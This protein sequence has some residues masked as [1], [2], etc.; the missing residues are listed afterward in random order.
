MQVTSQVPWYKERW[1]W[2]LAIMP[3]TTIIV[4][5]VFLW[6][7]I[8]TND[9]L[10]SDDYYKDGLAINRI[11]KR[12]EAAHRYNLSAAAQLRGSSISLQLAGNLP[13]VPDS[14]KLTLAH[15]T[16]EGF[17]RSILLTRN[18]VGNYQ[19]KVQGLINVRYD[20]ILEPLDGAWRIAGQWHPV[21]GEML[22]MNPANLLPRSE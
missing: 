2:L 17:D 8:K 10:V 21:E 14:L 7:A 20:I 5:S 1:P 13:A 4:C 18:Q 11:I 22:K 6:A 3:V 15:P 19:G 9:G 16:R 12:D